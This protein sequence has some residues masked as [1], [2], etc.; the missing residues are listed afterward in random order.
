MARWRLD[1]SSTITDAR[2]KV[3]LNKLSQLELTSEINKLAIL[4]TYTVDFAAATV[5][6]IKSLAS[7]F[8]NSLTQKYSLKQ[9][10]LAEGDLQELTEGFDFNW[11]IEI[12]YLPGVTDNIGN[13][14]QS[15]I[16][17]F[18]KTKF[19]D[20]E[21][22][23]SSQVFLI[24]ADLNAQDI[25]MISMALY[26]PL[27][28]RATILSREDFA[29]GR[30]LALHIPKVNLSSADLCTEVDLNISD[31]ELTSLGKEGINHRGPLALDL[32]YMK[33]IQAHFTKL[34]RKATDLELESIAQTWSE[35]C[36]H[37]IFA[38]PIDEIQDGLYKAYIK[39][40]TNE[41]RKRKAADTSNPI[42]DF[43]VSV[44]SDN[45][46]L[47]NFDDKHLI[48]H[49]V[50]THNSPSALDPFGGAITGIVGVNRDAIGCGL[51]AKPVANTYGFCFADPNDEEPIYR[52][53]DLSEK[54]LSPKRILEGVVHGVNVGGNC[55][56]IPTVHGFSYFHPRYKGKPLV[57][58][59]TLG[60]LPK[61]LAGDRAS[62]L[63]KAQPGD[64]IVMV[65]GRVGQDGIHGA[66]FSSVEMDS[67]SPATAVQIGD[68]ITQKKFSDAI[69]KEARDLNLYSS[70][71]DNGAGGLSCSVAE[72]AREAG[73]CYVELNKVPLKYP[74][75]AAWKV[76]I[77]ESQER[78]TL[79]VPPDKW[80]AFAELM[81][82]R[83]V[84]ATVIGKFTDSGKCEVVYKLD[85]SV[86][87]LMDLELEFLHNGLPAQALKTQAPTVIRASQNETE[88]RE[89]L[90]T[91][92]FDGDYGH[93][94]L[95]ML[96]RLNLSSNEF[97]SEQYDHEVQASS[98]VKPLQ[99]KGRVNGE[100][101]V[102]R[103]VL[104]SNKAVL[105]TSALYPSY[106]EI[107]AYDMAASA[108]DSAV[109][110][111]ICG[112]ASLDHLALLDNF[113]WC[114][115]NEPERL[116][117]LKEAAR[118]CYDYAIAY[119]TPYIS[120]KD[121]M[122]N[123]FRGYDAS[124]KNI[125]ISAPPTLLISALGVLND[126]HLATTIDYKF[127][128]DRIYLLGET[129]DE[130]G[131]SEFYS[132]INEVSP[133]AEAFIRGSCPQVNATKNLELYRFFEQ[134]NRLGYI[135]SAISV[136]H[137]GLASALAK[138][139]IAGEL[140]CKVSL[141]AVPASTASLSSLLFSESQGRII[142]TI[143]EALS[144][145]FE[146]ELNINQTAR[147]IGEVTA[148]NNFI[149]R[150]AGSELLN[151]NLDHMSSSYKERFAN[152]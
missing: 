5:D 108:I 125:K 69:V 67:S 99:G 68:P 23:Y 48:S 63:K 126:Y 121:S 38:D 57:F 144:E 100:H 60:L 58:V 80:Q 90:L 127:A 77:S 61:Q 52:D 66:T 75:L 41:I 51:G 101:S 81:Q 148:N 118:A 47:I 129:A 78:M 2:A 138:A 17:D 152:F 106:T 95:G 107:N 45:A 93:C 140:G 33:A 3:T 115:S 37:T 31:E 16:E 128:G 151:I 124:G 4:D 130:M 28:Q 142:F 137:G 49:K 132:M 6:S 133:S 112:G 147:N 119:G 18:L 26:N 59:G 15:T 50:E 79:S 30:G 36:K 70:I 85:Q 120:G 40:A 43:C 10:L 14:A 11:A 64:L 21:K 94:M 97:I 110:A 82:R 131:G 83:G 116:Y 27:I 88:L 150:F 62:H 19:A 74:G 71:T 53:A 44:F 9:S 34:G 102:F 35:H 105:V 54:M 139:S 56:G 8:C 12:G 123:D 149:I 55:S 141:D 22:V 46:G 89:E 134:A 117:Q 20:D 113:C 73:G 104:N 72:M 29:K 98:V 87:K 24:D 96:S 122:F 114:S 39:G 103:P 7:L 76:W 65:G 135:S 143:P 32:S 145:R 42:G 1:I 91:E 84:E 92:I 13:T 111:A 109:R 136:G 86:L 146:K 25:T